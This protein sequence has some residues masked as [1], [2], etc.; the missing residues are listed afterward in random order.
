M[1]FSP[2]ILR[3][4][5]IKTRKGNIAGVEI[6]VF[7]GAEF[8]NVSYDLYTTPPWLDLAVEKMKQAF[9]VDLEAQVVEEQARRL[10]HELRV[11]S[12]RVN[13]F[14]KVKIPEAQFNI[15]KINVFLGDQQTSAVVRGKISKKKLAQR[16]AAAKEEATA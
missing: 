3:I 12:Q 1:V 11:T 14:E 16:D 8:E 4:K 13:L 10:E 2:D 5:S 7:D 15:K 9:L 6:P